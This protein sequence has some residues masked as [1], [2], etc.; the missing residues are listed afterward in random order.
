VG[1]SG[2]GRGGYN[3][4]ESTESTNQLYENTLT[5]QKRFGKLG[6]SALA[7]YSYQDFL[8]KG[9]L[10]AGGNF[11]TDVSGQDFFTALDFNN[12][13]GLVDSYKNG[14]KL[15]AFF[16]RLN[17]NY[18]DIAYLS[19]SL[20]REGSTQ[21]GANNK[22][23][24]FPAV[25]AG[26]NIDALMDIPTVNSLKLRA[27]YGVTGSLPIRSYLSLQTLVPGGAKF[28]AG[29]NIYIPSYRP[30]KNA[31]PDLKWEKKAEFDIG[32]D[33]SL[34]DNRLSGTFDYYDRTTS[35]LIF[36]VTVPVPPNLAST[37]FKNIGELRSSGI[38][39]ALNYEVIRLSSFSW[40]T[41]GN[42]ST[43]NVK[44]T[45][46]N[47][48]SLRASFVGA[49]N[50]GTPG[51]E[52]TQITRA[53]EGYDIGTLWGPIYEGVDESGKYI[54]KD[55]TD[56][57]KVD[58]GDHTEIGNGLPKFQYGWTN[59]FRYKNFDFNFLLRGS[60]GHDLIN[61]YRAFY[62]NPNVASSYN[63]VSTKYFNPAVTDGQ[64]FSSLFVEKASFVKLDNATL[65]YT[66]QL[67]TEGAVKSLRW[68]ITGQ[69]LFLISDYTG[70]DPEV[71][72]ADVSRN[73]RGVV[74]TNVLAPGVDRRENWVFT[75]SFTLGVNIQF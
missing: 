5:Y 58:I 59:T 45:K 56:D 73:D 20:R 50:L 62:E 75:R 37:T 70:V 10:V 51:Q 41:G 24:M 7:G 54:L 31:N 29:N 34:L 49:T 64:V 28:Y 72:F 4:K 27:S 60:V 65:G 52:Q 14:S 40:T 61:T 26:V 55:L 66:F 25:S 15:V 42:F 1:V 44:L 39:L 71:R 22:W 57:G 69:N 3:W 63:V 32:L 48:P 12:G 53:R 18:N 8:N 13:K 21:F 67:P 6:V 9:F 17:L 16:G 23:G 36:D 74:T 33:F 38:E 2:F 68:Y 46:L 30:D 43:F 47:D 11:V 19:A 35:D